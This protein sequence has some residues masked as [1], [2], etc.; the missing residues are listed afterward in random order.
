MDTYFTN[1]HALGGATCAQVFYGVH[2]HMINVY[3]M[4]SE[5]EMPDA[6]KDFICDEGVPRI[7]CR[8]NSQIQK[9]TRTT[10]INREY[11]IKDQFTELEHPQQNPAELRAV[12]FLKDHSQVLLD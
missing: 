1:T 2:S 6:Y 7:L 3:G 11:F 4:K 12:K 5:S 10:K 9:G 8:D